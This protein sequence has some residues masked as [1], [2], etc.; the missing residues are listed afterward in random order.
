MGIDLSLQL[1]LIL[2]L[3]FLYFSSQVSGAQATVGYIFKRAS[4][5]LAGDCEEAQQALQNTRDFPWGRA[6][7]SSHSRSRAEN[8]A[9]MKADK[10]DEKRRDAEPNMLPG[11]KQPSPQGKRTTQTPARWGGTSVSGKMPCTEILFSFLV[12][13]SRLLSK[14]EA[15]RWKP[16]TWKTAC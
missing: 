4:S 16:G 5:N 6:G 14:N 12:R 8:K 3:Q 1:R 13:V 2:T 11:K 7:G 10:Q 15:Q 9:T